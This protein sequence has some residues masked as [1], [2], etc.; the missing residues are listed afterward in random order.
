MRHAVQSL[1]LIGLFLVAGSAAFAEHPRLLMTPE[2][3]RYIAANGDKSPSFMRSFAHTQQKVDKYFSVTPDVPT[4]LDAG[5]GYTHERHKKNGIAIHDAGVAYQLTGETRYADYAKELLFAYADIYPSLGEHPKKK[6]Q[7]PGRLFWQSLNEAVWLV[8]AIQG[9]DLICSSLGEDDRQR[10]ESELL[11]P[12][13]DFLSVESPETFDRIHNHGTWAVAAVGMTGYVIDDNEY[14]QQALYGLARDGESGFIKQLDM[15]FSPDGYYNEGPY[16]QR[17]ALM[18]FVLFARSIQANDP[19]LDIFQ[20]RDSILLKAIYSCVDLSYANLFFPINDAIKDKG[21][22]TVE[23]RYGL[24]VA[25]A[26]T[27]D[28]TL[29]SIAKAQKSIVLT[30]DGFQMAQ[31]IDSGLTKPFDFRSAV[32]RDGPLGDRGALVV[33]RQGDGPNHQALV[34]KATSQGMGHGH[35]DKLNWLYYD[36]GNEVIRDYGAA[37]FLNV[38]QKY[39]GHYLPENKSWAKQTIAHN[40]LVVDERSQ[41]GGSVSRGEDHHPQVMFLDSNDDIQIVGAVMKG[42]YDGVEFSR[43]QALLDG[44]VPGGA[45]VVDVLNAGSKQEH[46][47]DLPLHFNGQLITTSHPLAGYTDRLQPLGDANGYQHLWERARAEVESGDT[48]SLTWLLDDRFY[49][50]FAVADEDTQVLLAELGAN[51]P[52]HNLRHESALIL[53]VPQAKSQSFVSILEPHGEYN[54]PEEYTVDSYPRIEIVERYASNGSDVVRI[55]TH[56]GSETLLA[57]SYNP[58]PDADHSVA[59]GDR[60]INWKGYFRLIQLR[61]SRP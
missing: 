31:A 34:Q 18:P 41:F 8:Y 16:Y 11:R 10:I 53:R 22:D 25:Y 21:L 15:L 3:A 56:D 51:D 39:G 44:V 29:L 24:S 43:T 55:V 26:L 50:Q 35:F 46:Q 54:G 13:A 48:F 28:A 42:A 60:T 20:Y 47:Y 12:M 4:P 38:E 61:G 2:D 5:G 19:E 9:Y 32:L 57:L 45:I 49:T 23:L 36:N 40:T 7:S 59:V 14:V 52:N 30:G 1:I 58:D 6:E 33:F 37:R 17:Y 27:K